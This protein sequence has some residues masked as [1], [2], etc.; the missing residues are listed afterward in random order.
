MT[1][2]I[3]VDIIMVMNREGLDYLRGACA[4][5][6]RAIG[7]LSFVIITRSEDLGIRVTHKHKESVKNF[8]SIMLQIVW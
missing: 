3:F 6:C 2:V 1:F 5:E 4:A 8:A 7:R